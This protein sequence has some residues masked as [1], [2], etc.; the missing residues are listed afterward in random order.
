MARPEQ[1]TG[2]IG[3]TVGEATAALDQR[4]ASM[5][6]AIDRSVGDATTALDQ[7]TANLDRVMGER[8]GAI[9]QTLGA[10]ATRATA[11]VAGTLENAARRIAGT[12]AALEQTIVGRTANV[13]GE[14]DKRGIGFIHVVE[15]AT[16]EAR[17]YL[18]FDYQAL[19]Q[20]FRGAYIANNGFTRALAIEA[21]EKG[22]ADL[23]A[24]GRLF[25]ANPDLP[26]RLRLGA[27][28]NT[29]DTATF[30]GGDAK[31]YTDYPALTAPA[32]SPAA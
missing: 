9:S 20:G 14:L 10:E 32:A 2:R 6:A 5:T 19:R 12:T 13:V 23:V 30:Y 3:R 11:Q 16:R 27:P 31:G 21:V 8:L 28:L 25:I 17:D 7:R 26:E 18:P 1:F 24:F 4:A 22:E 29:P 15:G